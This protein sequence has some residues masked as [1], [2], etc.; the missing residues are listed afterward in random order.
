MSVEQGVREFVRWFKEYK[1]LRA[2]REEVQRNRPLECVK[3]GH[4]CEG[5]WLWG[6]LSF[7]ELKWQH[8]PGQI[9]IVL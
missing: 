2:K 5:A 7:S 8:L 6:I 9:D 1:A 4:S 3:K